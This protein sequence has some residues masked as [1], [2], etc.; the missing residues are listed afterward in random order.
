MYKGEAAGKNRVRQ[1]L[2]DARCSAAVVIVVDRHC[3][4]QEHDHEGENHERPQCNLEECIVPAVY[5]RHPVFHDGAVCGRDELLPVL[6][7]DKVLF[8]DVF[9][10]LTHTDVLSPAYRCAEEVGGEGVDRGTGRL[11]H[12]PK[13]NVSH[14]HHIE[15]SL[16]PD[17]ARVNVV[18]TVAVNMQRRVSVVSPVVLGD[19]ISF[20]INPKRLEFGVSKKILLLHRIVKAGEDVCLVAVD[21]NTNENG[22]LRDGASHGCRATLTPVEESCVISLPQ[23]HGHHGVQ[24]NIELVNYHAG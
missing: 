19:V 4:V 12:Y 6:N 15:H 18:H 11:G 5:R 3:Y 13:H 8:F 23:R 16:Q 1:E 21:R 20:L 22:T 17:D 24:L 14:G 7:F 9:V 2:V 10:G